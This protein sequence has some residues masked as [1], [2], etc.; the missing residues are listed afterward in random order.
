[1]REGE[2][3]VKYGAMFTAFLESERELRFSLTQNP[4]AQ[5]RRV[6][7]SALFLETSAVARRVST[8]SS[9]LDLRSQS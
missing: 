5:V 3:L 9:G 4:S 6:S 1:M 8:L 7:L 2:D